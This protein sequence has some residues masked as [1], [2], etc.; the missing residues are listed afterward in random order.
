MIWTG[1]SPRA[2]QQ[3]S[4]AAPH[5]QGGELLFKYLLECYQ[6]RITVIKLHLD[7]ST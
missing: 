5:S 2:G 6:I 3:W 7:I 1:L 4:V